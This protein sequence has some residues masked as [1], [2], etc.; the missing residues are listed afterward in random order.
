MSLKRGFWW[1]K[2]TG[3][4]AGGILG[5]LGLALSIFVEALLNGRLLTESNWFWQMILF[6]FGG[7]FA[8]GFVGAILGTILGLL[9]VWAQLDEWAQSIWSLAGAITGL[10]IALVPHELYSLLSPIVWVWVGGLVGWYAGYFFYNGVQVTRKKTAV[11]F[12][13]DPA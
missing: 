5:S 8:G 11:P 4:L 6:G 13:I 3:L 9:I 10:L 2:L 7:A 1:G 12:P